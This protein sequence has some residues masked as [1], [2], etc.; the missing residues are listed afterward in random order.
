MKD[1]T[2]TPHR[3]LAGRRVSQADVARVAGVSG[4]TVSRV[5]NGMT[6][7]EPATRD[8][9]LAAMRELGYRPNR[10]AR[11]IRSG[12]FGAIGVT[13][14]NL[15]SHG[16]VRTLSS[17]AK[18]LGE[19]GYSVTLVPVHQP[20]RAA[21]ADAFDELLGQAVDGVIPMIELP[22]NDSSQLVVPPQLP[23][24]VISGGAISG[25]FP[26]IDNDQVGG[27]QAAVRHLLSLG[28]RTV[29]LIGGP[30]ASFPASLREHAWRQALEEDGRPVPPVEHG[31]W[32]ADAG[33]RIGLRLGA[34]RQVTA[35]LAANDQMA[36]GLLRALHE[37]GRS[38]PRDISVVGFDD[39]PEASCFWPPLTTVSQAF[40]R[41]GRLAVGTLLEQIR[42]GRTTPGRS[43]VA[44]SLVVRASTGPAHR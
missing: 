28:H 34:E 31:D 13:A 40:E 38:V 6:N 17:I 14:F 7:V 36:L 21:L 32:S 19:E 23:V 4:Q 11:A 22:L 26:Y 15:E 25:D 43:V 8:R 12:E 1:L 2:R 24:V 35:I 27:T 30:E 29:H 9:V 10:A 33:Y 3:R 41:L 39:I 18:A 5:S 16:N 20:T 42:T 44:T 37:L